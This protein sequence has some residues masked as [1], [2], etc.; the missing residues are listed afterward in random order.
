MKRLKISNSIISGIKNSFHYT[1]LLTLS[2]IVFSGC[3]NDSFLNLKNKDLQ[4]KP[5]N[6]VIKPNGNFDNKTEKLP[7]FIV[8]QE[9]ISEAEARLL[10]DSLQISGNFFKEDGAIGYV[11]PELFQK[12]PTK[13]VPNGGLG[14][15]RKNSGESNEDDLETREEAID[16]EALKNLK[17][18]DEKIA[19]DRILIGLNK[20]NLLPQNTNTSIGHAEFEAKNKD[21]SEIF[22]TNLDTQVNFEL[23]LNNK[24]L[25]G[26]GAKI[27]AVFNGDGQVTRLVY[28]NRKLRQGETASLIPSSNAENIAIKLF[29]DQYGENARLKL[30]SELVYY[31]P[32]LSQ[33]GVSKIFPHYLI[34]GTAVIDGKETELRQ[35]HIPAVEET[36]NVVI[37]LSSSD[38]DIH[39]KAV[40]LG[41]TAPYTFKWSSNNTPLE[42]EKTEG[43]TI[44]YQP[45]ARNNE[46][47]L[48]ERL[49]LVVTDANGL[50]TIASSNINLNYGQ[51]K[52]FE[53]NFE[54]KSLARTDAGIEWVGLSQGLAGSA[55]NAGGFVRQFRANGVPV[56]FNF[57]DYSAWERDFKKVEIG[58]HDNSY[59]D[60]VDLTFYTGHANGNGFTFPGTMD[61]H[62]LDY[63]EAKYGDR[64][65]EWL[66]IAACGPLQRFEGGIHLFDRWGGAFAGLHLL[67]GYA[68]VSYDNTVEG[69]KFAN[70]ILRSRLTV[71]QAWACTA[72][73][74]QPSSVT[75]GYMGVFNSRGVSNFNDHFWGRGSVGPDITDVRG[76]F[77]VHSPS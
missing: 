41:G 9:G 16:F 8:T 10:A 73:E 43:E 30:N 4:L 37:E 21:G 12:I 51:L 57:G 53:G 40:V 58:G 5:V 47:H 52:H 28:A 17:I 55:G 33:K 6:P 65:L 18:L 38:S 15:A 23:H 74:V 25:V 39:A 49:N 46:R 61:D 64:D 26:P 69:E 44:Q 14:E 2:A 20:A 50:E 29:K 34:G 27:K 42:D 71:S 3:G 76:Y 56:E 13:P 1:T 59:A 35:V 32:P 22:K 48:K 31:A 62:F 36:P 60:N 70:Y 45:V 77:S 11:N 67:A 68:N 72:T 24:K 19:L 54:T 63:T 7:V 75:Y 66:I